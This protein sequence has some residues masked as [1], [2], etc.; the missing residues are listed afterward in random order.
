MSADEG[1]VGLELLRWSSR[2]HPDE[3]TEHSMLA[4]NGTG[5]RFRQI[6]DRGFL[7]ALIGFLRSCRRN[8]VLCS[9]VAEPLQ[10]N[11]D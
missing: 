5:M 9:C 6:V 1:R 10:I 3:G 4:G 2:G 11:S 7:V 8:K